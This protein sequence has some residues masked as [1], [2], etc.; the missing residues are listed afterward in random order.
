MAPLRW[1][2]A[3]ALPLGLLT[4]EMHNR[5]I[6]DAAFA[7][8]G[9]AVR[10]VFETNSVLALLLAVT[11]GAVAA[12][13]MP[14]VL[15]GQARRDARLEIV[16]LV[17]PEVTVTMGLLA[18]QGGRLSLAQQAALGCVAEAGWWR[19]TVDLGGGDHCGCGGCCGAS[20]IP[21]I[22]R[23]TD[24]IGQRQGARSMIGAWRQDPPRRAAAGR[25]WTRC[26]PHMPAR[27]APCC[28]SCMRCRTGSASCRRRHYRPSRAR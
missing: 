16:P 6:V 9:V 15:A 21:A 23:F 4:P 26:W 3:A 25:R 18:P 7:Q 24:V 20:F 1:R 10:P 5:H 19:E 12:S 14:G 22:G 28:R 8:A 11:E 2:E 13:I 27:L 17:E